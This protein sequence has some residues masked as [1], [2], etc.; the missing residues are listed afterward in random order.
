MQGCGT[1]GAA[2]A[3][4]DERIMNFKRG[5]WVKAEE[6]L[7]HW[8]SKEYP[9]GGAGLAMAF[10]E[11]LLEVMPNC[12]IGFVPCAV[13]GSPLANWEPGQLLF[14]NAVRQTLN[15]LQAA[16]DAEL[17]GIL[18]HHGEYDAQSAETA[19]TYKQ[20]LTDIVRSFRQELNAP[21][22]P[23]IAGEMGHFLKDNPQFPFHREVN[24]AQRQTV[25]ALP[26][27]GWA[28]AAGLTDKDRNDLT[29]FDAASLKIF[30]R[31]YAEAF[32]LV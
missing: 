17:S 7:H 2:E 4:D 26:F 29:H 30:G 6:P 8:K 31:R 21:A 12:T 28:G 20:R 11:R 19:A 25:S 3:V 18:W 27:T 9:D 23:F 22:L 15:S 14:T 13:S 16:P 10:A 5:N 24:Q 32:M 1:I